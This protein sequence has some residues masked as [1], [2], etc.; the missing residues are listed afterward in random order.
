MNFLTV[1]PP[2]NTIVTVKLPSPEVP[3]SQDIATKMPAG[4]GAQ[5]KML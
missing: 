5:L 1:H 3:V 2:G 4:T